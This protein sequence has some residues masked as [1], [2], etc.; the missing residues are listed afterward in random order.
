MNLIKETAFKSLIH[1]L[2]HVC[3]GN[4]NT[5]KRFHLLQDNILNGVLH[6]VNGTFSS[7]LS[8]PDNGIC[9]VEQQNRG[10]LEF[11]DLLAIGIKDLLDILFAFTDPHTFDFRDI[12][13]HD[14]SSCPS[15]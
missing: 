4:Q 15:G 10:N 8:F 5:I 9:L 1:V 2:R 13:L 3:S 7:F 11:F 14:I 6:F 12:Y